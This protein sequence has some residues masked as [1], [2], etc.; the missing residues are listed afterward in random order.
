MTLAPTSSGMGF[1][2]N[3]YKD[4]RTRIRDSGN[5]TSN[6]RYVVLERQGEKET[7]IPS[8]HLRLF[9]GIGKIHNLKVRRDKM[10]SYQKYIMMG[11]STVL[12]PLAKRMVQRLVERFTGKLQNDSAVEETEAFDRAYGLSDKSVK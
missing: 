3:P 6:L 1:A 2:N 11:V 8:S 7:G 9:H 5:A 12:L 10:A 4:W